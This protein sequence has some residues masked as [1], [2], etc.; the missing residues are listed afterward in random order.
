MNLTKIEKIFLAVFALGI[1]AFLV[2]EFVPFDN[3][4]KR[5][6]E[7]SVVAEKQE[8]AKS[9]DDDAKTVETTESSEVKTVETDKS[10]AETSEAVVEQTTDEDLIKSYY[11][12][13]ASQD[14]EGAYKM[15][16]DTKKVTFA[17]FK[18]W[19]QNV[20]FADVTDVVQ[21]GEGSYQFTVYLREKNTVEE[22][23]LVT[24]E[25]KDGLLNTISTEKTWDNYTPEFYTE[26]TNGIRKL[27]IKKGGTD[28][29]LMTIDENQQ[30]GGYVF[31]SYKIF[32]NNKYLAYTILGNG[33][34]Y[35]AVHIYDIDN[36][37][38]VNLI[39][40]PG[41]Y[42]FTSDGES[43]YQCSGMGMASGEFTVFSVPTFK[44]F[45]SAGD[46]IVECK[47]YNKDMNAY[48]LVTG[49]NQN[50]PKTYYFSENV[51]R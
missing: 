15:K 8:I 24:M 39:N 29:V 19:Y 49:W 9:S 50:I 40:G 45:Y 7:E 14:L 28:K 48:F 2:V 3:K 18:S 17:Q 16:Y 37:R 46:Q 23:Y 47:G 51:M 10:V 22:K 38:E 35:R 4:T 31:D 5:P 12:K 1:V 20:L 27:H 43:F 26:V 30:V 21:K 36:G 32:E 11:N 6:V 44:T 33:W 13:L 41:D 42:G 25:V 34:G